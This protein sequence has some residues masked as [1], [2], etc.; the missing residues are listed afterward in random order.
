MASTFEGQVRHGKGR[1]RSVSRK[2]PRLLAARAGRALAVCFAV[3]VVTFLLVRVV[4]GDPVV[5]ITGP[6]ASEQAREE[7]REQLHLNESLPAQFVAYV[8]DLARGDLGDSLTQQGKSV[9]S[10]IGSTLPIT[11]LLVALTIVI[12]VLVGVPLG[13]LAAARAGPLDMLIRGFLTVLLSVPP[14]FFGLLLILFVALDAGIL[15]AGG[16]P[17]SWPENLR[18]LL[19]PSIALS[20]FLLAIV[21]RATRQA[22]LKAFSDPW[23][24]AAIARGLS[25]TR[26]VFR[27]V[28]PNSVLPVITLLGFNAGVLIAGAVVVESVFALP[29]I[30]QELV[31][32]VNQRNY[33][34]IQG[35]ALVTALIVVFCNLVAELA[36]AAADPRVGSR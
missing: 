23:A 29:G 24:E 16:W 2:W 21:A 28:L 26:V 17:G 35:I 8:G 11:L 9:T 15:P 1:R 30:G 7:V 5:A 12:S 4:P 20:A 6:R 13:L 36:A 32:A 22:A 10:I 31:S 27:H 34:I 18:F 3:V 19:L 14:F 25:P 33:P